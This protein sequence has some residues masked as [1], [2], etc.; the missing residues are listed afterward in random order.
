[1]ELLA[2]MP[3]SEVNRVSMK[4]PSHLASSSD[5]QGIPLVGIAIITVD[6]GQAVY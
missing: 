1:M 3:E 4:H 2:V 6:D 5:D